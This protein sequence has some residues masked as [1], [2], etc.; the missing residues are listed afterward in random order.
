MAGDWIKIRTWIAK[1]PKVIAMAR[2]LASQREYMNWL[3]DPVQQH[4]KESAFEHVTLDVTVRVT[5]TGLVQVW[6]VTRPDGVPDNDDL[7]VSKID[8]ATLDEIAGVPRFGDAMASVGWA[9]EE[10]GEQVRFP[11]FFCQ[12]ASSEELRRKKEAERK[13]RWRHNQSTGQSTGQ[14]RDNPHREE[15]SKVLAAAA[16]PRFAGNLESVSDVL[17]FGTK[18]GVTMDRKGKLQMVGYAAR[19]MATAKRSRRGLF[20]KMVTDLIAGNPS[21]FDD[22]PAERAAA[23]KALDAWEA[24]QNGTH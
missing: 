4:C 21:D 12:N 9:V 22:A 6:G 2:F 8:L 3:S 10:D 5:V 14:S 11:K 20:S 17:D 23:S 24:S 19:A 15:K 1:D 7:L 16:A 13:R 18:T